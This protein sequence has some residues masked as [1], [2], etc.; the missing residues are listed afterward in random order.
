MT[1]AEKKAQELGVTVTMEQ[2]YDFIKT[3]QEA[4]KDT[5]DLIESGMDFDEASV[6]AYMS[7]C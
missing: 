6:L 2:V 5:N 7:W 1:R 3:H 4:K